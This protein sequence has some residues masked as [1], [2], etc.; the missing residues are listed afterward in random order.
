MAP[1]PHHRTVAFLRAL[2]APAFLALAWL[3]LSSAAAQADSRS[4]STTLPTPPIH[5]VPQ[6]PTPLVAPT[7]T[8]PI[9]A[10]PVSAPVLTALGAPGQG[11]PQVIGAVVAQVND[12]G[13]VVEAMTVPILAQV[14]SFTALVEASPLPVLVHP[15]PEVAPELDPSLGLPAGLPTPDET[16]LASPGHLTAPHGGPPMSLSEPS[17]GAT[18]STYEAG[19]PLVA[20]QSSAESNLPESAAT[21]PGNGPGRPAHPPVA[22]PD[23]S[24]LT[25]S[26]GNRYASSSQMSA[27]PA[28]SDLV[29]GP[30]HTAGGPGNGWKLPASL[31]IPPGSSPD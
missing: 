1:Q 3:V 15:V 9:L 8:P 28:Y 6:Q 19:N 30:H 21:V 14:P 24:G 2:V 22:P 7:P 20:P 25:V 26:S 18:T 29:G 31:S 13:G 23:V 10:R 11:D 12:L 4:E 16:A 27:E 5:V 17:A